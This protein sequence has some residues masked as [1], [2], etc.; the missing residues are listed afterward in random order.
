M[1]KWRPHI[2]NRQKKY[3]FE[4]ILYLV[5]FW[6][7][8]FLNLD[9]KKLYKNTFQTLLHVNATIKIKNHSSK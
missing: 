7:I 2:L 9:F 5:Q 8:H 4:L 3:G 1:R 6:K